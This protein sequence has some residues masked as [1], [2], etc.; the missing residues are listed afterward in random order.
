MI[1]LVLLGLFS[2]FLTMPGSPV[3]PGRGLKIAFVLIAIVTSIRYRYGNDYMEYFYVFQSIVSGNTDMDEAYF[4]YSEIFDPGWS[5]FCY[6]FKPFGFYWMVAF[7]SCFKALAAYYFI[8]DNVPSRYYY[9]S[10]LFYMFTTMLFPI[11]LSMM[12]QGFVIDVFMLCFGLIKRK[13]ILI[14]LLAMLLMS[15]IH[16]TSFVLVPFIFWYYIPK[17]ALKYISIGILVLF[18]VFLVS[19]EALLGVFNYF[20]AFE[21]FEM[22][23]KYETTVE[24]EFGIRNMIRVIPA[25]VTTILLFKYNSSYTNV[26]NKGN[27]NGVIQADLMT[28]PP[29]LILIPSFVILFMPFNQIMPMLVRVG[30]FF[31]QFIIVAFPFMFRYMEKDSRVVLFSLLLIVMLYENYIF[32]FGDIYSKYFLTYHTLFEL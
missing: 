12:R 19:K 24:D 32:Y 14:P 27:I 7:L 9:I 5:V 16:K 15:Q 30:F 22:Y 4:A 25:I 20:F 2:I 29:H 8:K 3:K 31:N 6:L 23:Q 17:V 10:I 13:K 11:Q 18:F 26:S 21:L 28:F 1:V